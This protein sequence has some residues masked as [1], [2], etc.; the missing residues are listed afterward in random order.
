LEGVGV[1]TPDAGLGIGANFAIRRRTLERLGGFDPLLGVGAPFFRAGEDVDVLI[2]ALSA[3]YRVVNAVECDVLHV[4]TRTGKAVRPLAVGYQIGTGAALG[5]HARLAGPTGL[6]DLCRWGLFYLYEAVT[7][8]TLLGRP[9]LGVPFY[10]VA[11]VLLTYRYRIDRER[12][13]LAVR[14]VSIAP[15]SARSAASTLPSALNA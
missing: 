9:R 11:G 1:P 4:G 3:G 5:K 6:R 12:Q 8:S 14:G 7:R 15:A 10:F 2:R 13:A